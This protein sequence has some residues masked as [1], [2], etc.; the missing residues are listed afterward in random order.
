MRFGFKLN[1]PHSVANQLNKRLIFIYNGAMQLIRHQAATTTIQK[2]HS[3]PVAHIDANSQ[4]KYRE[5]KK[6]VNI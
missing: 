3:L 2:A 6:N 4:I 1:V 5:G